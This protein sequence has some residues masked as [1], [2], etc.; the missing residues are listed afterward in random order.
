MGH[1]F[2]DLYHIFFCRMVTFLN[3]DFNK[4]YEYQVFKY[5]LITD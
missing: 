5:L 2:I 4:Y 3:L 1:V